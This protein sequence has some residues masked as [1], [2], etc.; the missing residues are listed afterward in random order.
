MID[1]PTFQINISRDLSRED[2]ITRLKKELKKLGWTEPVPV[3]PATPPVS[4][5]V[6]PLSCSKPALATSVYLTH[7][8]SQEFI[9]LRMEA[10]NLTGKLQ[11]RVIIYHFRPLDLAALF[12]LIILVDLRE[13]GL[14]A[15]KSFPFR[16]FLPSFGF[17]AL[18]TA[19]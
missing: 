9:G 4:M 16:P 6:C 18:I 5:E 19:T 11:K 13:V 7:S 15:D 12:A 10:T 17:W 3:R 8:K 1:H 14:G 2:Q